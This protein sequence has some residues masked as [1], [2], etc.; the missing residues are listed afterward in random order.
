[1]FRILCIHP[2]RL[3]DLTEKDFPEYLET[4]H[5]KKLTNR[6]NMLASMADP[7]FTIQDQEGLMKELNDRIRMM[8]SLIL[9]K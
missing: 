9:T 5:T 1:M 8:V 7:P 3:L 2:L 6:Y 4:L